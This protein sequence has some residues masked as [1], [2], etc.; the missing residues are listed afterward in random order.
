MD[1]EDHVYA[2]LD[3]RMCQRL[4]LGWRRD[5][6]ISVYCESLRCHLERDGRW[7]TYPSPV[8]NTDLRYSHSFPRGRH[9]G[10]HSAN[11]QQDVDRLV[12]SPSPELG[13][14]ILP[15]PD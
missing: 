6:V 7:L 11:E 10:C 13:L 5:C 4:R 15:S 3:G 2:R 1:V 12:D 8:S 9:A 14:H